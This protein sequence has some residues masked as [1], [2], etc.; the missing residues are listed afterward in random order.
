[1][2]DKMHLG[3]QRERLISLRNHVSESLGQCPR[4]FDAGGASANDHKVQS[5]LLD[6]AVERSVVASSTSRSAAAESFGVVHRVERKGVLGRSRRIEE[7]RLGARRKDQVVP[8]L[9]F[10]PNAVVTERASGC[11]S[12]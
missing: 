11:G 10:D 5:T 2:I 4:R 8:R 6:E 1:M 12:M 3:R 9:S 7:V